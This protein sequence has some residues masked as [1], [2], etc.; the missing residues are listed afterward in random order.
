VEA[1]A[2]EATESEEV[3]VFL[4]PEALMGKTIKAGDTFMMKAKSVD[5]ETQEVEAVYVK[6][7]YGGNGGEGSMMDD[8]EQAVPE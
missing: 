6:D 2:P 5:P 1:P 4:P 7:S 8:F 3:S